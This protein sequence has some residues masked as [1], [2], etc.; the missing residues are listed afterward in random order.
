LAAIRHQLAR[1]I[2]VVIHVDRTAGEPERHVSSVCEVVVPGADSTM[3]PTLR[4]L[5]ER[6]A[7]GSFAMFAQLTRG[8]T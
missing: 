8:R 5:G 4:T 6:R 7:D 1:S 2:D 3:P